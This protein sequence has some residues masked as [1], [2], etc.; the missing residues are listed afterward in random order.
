M[1]LDQALFNY[2]R[3]KVAPQLGEHEHY[4]GAAAINCDV[5]QTAIK[6]Y[7]GM[8]R[9]VDL[10]FLE[11]FQ[12][13]LTAQ[14]LIMIMYTHSYFMIIQKTVVFHGPGEAN[15]MS[16][17]TKKLRAEREIMCIISDYATPQHLAYQIVV[18]L[19]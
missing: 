4:L 13:I 16:S 18:M 7:W 5:K 19:L 12:F 11:A 9:R 10:I 3:K 8:E 6:D 1:W 17:K 14:T 2:G 15:K